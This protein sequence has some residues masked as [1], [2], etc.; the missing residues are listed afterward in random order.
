MPWSL[1]PAP[2]SY[3]GHEYDT[4]LQRKKIASMFFLST[5]IMAVFLLFTFGKLGI[6]AHQFQSS[7]MMNQGKKEKEQPKWDIYGNEHFT[8]I[9][10]KTW[11]QVQTKKF[12]IVHAK[13]YSQ[14]RTSQE[15]KGLA[16]KD[17]FIMLF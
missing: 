4:L 14:Q 5:N 12:S 10:F 17:F 2:S 15:Q 13:T 16:R 1:W 11:W 9:I 3:R 8:P 7:H 6:R